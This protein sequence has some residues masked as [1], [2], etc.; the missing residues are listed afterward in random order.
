MGVELGS[1]QQSQH[2]NSPSTRAAGI[3]LH[4]PPSFFQDPQGC[5]A[6]LPKSHLLGDRRRGSNPEQRAGRA[7]EQGGS[8]G[9]GSFPLYGLILLQLIRAKT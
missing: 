3:C 2:S 5:H 4:P 8:G 6:L 9:R 1:S 7:E